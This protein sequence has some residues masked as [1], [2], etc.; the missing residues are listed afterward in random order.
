MK[1]HVANERQA[2]G[3]RALPCSEDIDVRVTDRQPLRAT[4]CLGRW[5]TLSFPLVGVLVLPKLFADEALYQ[6]GDF[7]SHGKHTC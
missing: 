7:S 5:D 1:R 4:E 6:V 2:E 3:Y